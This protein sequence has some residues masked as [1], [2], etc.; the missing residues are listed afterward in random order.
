MFCPVD[1]Y[2]WLESQPQYAELLS[3]GVAYCTLF[4]LHDL[5]E[6]IWDLMKTF[7]SARINP[8]TFST[9]L[10]WHAQN[11]WGDVKDILIIPAPEM[12]NTLSQDKF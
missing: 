2:Y 4:L 9:T 7:Y 1:T 10:A 8:P 5:G 12:L 11:G 3:I 6:V